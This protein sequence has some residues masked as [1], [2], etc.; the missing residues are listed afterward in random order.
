MT[1]FCRNSSR[2]PVRPGP[3]KVRPDESKRNP[4]QWRPKRHRTA[5]R[6][7]GW[8]WKRDPGCPKTRARTAEEIRTRTRA[9]TL[10]NDA[11]APEPPPI[12]DSWRRARRC[13]GGRQGV[14]QGWRT[15]DR[16]SRSNSRKAA[17]RNQLFRQ[18]PQGRWSEAAAELFFD[19]I[20]SAAILILAWSAPILGAARS[21][22]LTPRA[23]PHGFSSL[24]PLGPGRPR[25]KHAKTRIAGLGGSLAPP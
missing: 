20:G 17:A 5:G 4:G 21:E 11:P 8:Q 24:G 9:A 13:A 6:V 16:H 10:R 14:S 3:E 25:S 7:A 2:F 23:I 12:S 19:G 15:E 18:T 1:A 22:I